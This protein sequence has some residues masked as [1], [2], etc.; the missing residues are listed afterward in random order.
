[1]IDSTNYNLDGDIRTTSSL[2]G[3][4]GSNNKNVEGHIQSI[5]S[6]SGT[7]YEGGLLKG[8]DGVSPKISVEVIDNGYRI[9]IDDISGIK[10][11]NVYNG[12]HGKPFTYEDFTE[13]QLKALVGP[14]GTG[15]D[16]TGAVVGQIPQIAS[17]DES[18][19][20]TSWVST[21]AASF[22][23][24]VFKYDSA[25]RKYV[26]DTSIE[27]I[28][29]AL[30]EGR[31]AIANVDGTDY[32]PLLSA[33]RGGN[34][35]IIFSG[36]YN[37]NAVSFTVYPTDSGGLSGELNPTT[38]L[39]SSGTASSARKLS[40]SRTI[41]AD[42]STNKAVGFDGS[43]NITIGATGVLPIEKGGTGVTSIEELKVL[44]GLSDDTSTT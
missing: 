34:P 41:I 12:E 8:E 15:L 32:I 23:T 9:T 20:P 38:L 25:A 11:V 30:D 6:V 35:Y 42:L 17:V 36:I 33:I 5:N 3:F 21:D 44:L 39:H 37:T 26:S 22:V 28:F 18:G 40:S 43:A 29:K 19:V 2:T 7:A 24:A 10:V 16:M 13:E 1:M 31:N 4:V 14:P 27:E